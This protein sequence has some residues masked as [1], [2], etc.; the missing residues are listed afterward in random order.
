ME[1]PDQHK[2][3]SLE[4]LSQREL[5]DRINKVSEQ[6]RASEE[7]LIA[8]HQE[9]DKG[10]AE[11][12]A[13]YAERGQVAGDKEAFKIV[14]AKILALE[15]E[16]EIDWQNMQIAVANQTELFRELSELHEHQR[17]TLGRTE[18]TS[19]A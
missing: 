17:L 6:L 18:P 19:E 4:L 16:L 14:D 10:R 12:E 1:K 15:G 13:L 2:K 9:Y 3:R 5:Q 8:A 11:R 7:A